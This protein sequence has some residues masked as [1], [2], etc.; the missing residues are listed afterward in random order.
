MIK[1]GEAALKLAG[2]IARVLVTLKGGQKVRCIN[3]DS[4][5]Y[6]SDSPYRLKL[7]AVYTIKYT[8]S[9]PYISYFHFIELE[10]AYNSVRFEYVK[11]NAL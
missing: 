11:E 6:F 9:K 8:E 5:P 1:A 10:G 4:D 2:A 7:N 3:V